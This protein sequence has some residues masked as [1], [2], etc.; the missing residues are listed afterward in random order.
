MIRLTVLAAVIM[1]G[2][3]AANAD[4]PMTKQAVAE[5]AKAGIDFV[6][7]A[8]IE[9]RRAENGS[10]LLIDVRTKR[11]F[12]LAH[13]PGATWVPR[14]TAEFEIAEK[15]RDAN[16][17]IIVYCRTGNRAALVKKALDQQGYLNVSAHSGFE[18]WSEAGL[19]VANELGTLTLVVETAEE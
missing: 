5:A 19:P 14:G 4:E 18:A 12:D 6:D 8:H 10:L 13:I 2:F 16:Q 1:I 3:G 17:E 15:V 11:E 7:N 9:A